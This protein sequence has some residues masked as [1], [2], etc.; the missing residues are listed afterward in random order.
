MPPTFLRS[1]LIIPKDQLYHYELHKIVIQEY[2]KYI[3]ET[4][5]NVKDISNRLSRADKNYSY[6]KNTKRKSTNLFSSFENKLNEILLRHAN[7]FGFNEQ[8]KEHK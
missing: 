7:K 5:A 4:C 8:K 2:N 6:M 3:E 1:M